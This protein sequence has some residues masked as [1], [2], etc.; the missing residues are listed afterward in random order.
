MRVLA[1]FTSKHLSDGSVLLVCRET[2]TRY[3]YCQRSV[4]ESFPIFRNGEVMAY[5]RGTSQALGLI[6]SY[7]RWE[8]REALRQERAENGHRASVWL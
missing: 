2:G 1:T 3:S 6:E 7:A 5:R 8:L 4:F